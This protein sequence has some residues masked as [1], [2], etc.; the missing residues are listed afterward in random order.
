[1]LI[2]PPGRNAVQMVRVAGFYGDQLNCAP[3]SCH[4]T[5]TGMDSDMSASILPTPEM[6]LEGDLQQKQGKRER[7]MTPS[8]LRA[9]PPSVS[10]T[11]RLCTATLWKRS[12]ASSK[13]NLAH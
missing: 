5:Y 3:S 12:P 9:H 8:L 13:T 11:D 1:M 2:R 10:S 6:L 7:D 4:E